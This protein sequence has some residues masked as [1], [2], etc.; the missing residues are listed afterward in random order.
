[1]LETRLNFDDLIEKA[2]Y[3]MIRGLNSVGAVSPR[4]LFMRKLLIGLGGQDA[5]E[6]F[7]EGFLV[8][9]ICKPYKNK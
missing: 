9:L 5:Y 3:G 2:V 6:K 7:N 4:C 8:G 1:M